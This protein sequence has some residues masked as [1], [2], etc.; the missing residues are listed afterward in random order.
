MSMLSISHVRLPDIPEE[1]LEDPTPAANAMILPLQMQSTTAIDITPKN[2]NSLEDTLEMLAARS[3]SGGSGNAGAASS[4]TSTRSIRATDSEN[5]NSTAGAENSVMAPLVREKTQTAT[6]SSVPAQA[7]Q[8]G[9]GNDQSG[10]HHDTDSTSSGGATTAAP[11]PRKSITEVSTECP[12]NYISDVSKLREMIRRKAKALDSSDQARA[13]LESTVSEYV[14]LVTSLQK[15]IGAMQMQ[16]LDDSLESSRRSM[17]ELVRARTHNL[18]SSTSDYISHVQLAGGSS[19]SSGTGISTGFPAASIPPTSGAGV[20]RTSVLSTGGAREEDP[21]HGGT[22]SSSSAPDM[23]ELQRVIAEKTADISTLRQQLANADAKSRA[24]QLQLESDFMLI[25][26]EQQQRVWRDLEAQMHGQYRVMFAEYKARK[27]S[28]AQ[29]VCDDAKEALQREA[30]DLRTRVEKEWSGREAALRDEEA[31]RFAIVE[32]QRSAERG[33]LET[34]VKAAEKRAQAA[35]SERDALLEKQSALEDD[36]TQKLVDLEKKLE[37]AMEMKR[38]LENAAAADRE[39]LSLAE[40]EASGLAATHEAKLRDAISAAEEKAKRAAEAEIGSARAALEQKFEKEADRW[41]ADFVKAKETELREIREKVEQHI[42][43]YTSEL[44]RKIAAVEN[45]EKEVAEK[46]TALTQ[47]QAELEEKRLALENEQASFRDELQAELTKQTE[48][49]IASE[50]ARLARLASDTAS[51]LDDR[52]ASMKTA[53]EDREASMKTAL[54]DREASMQT[55]LEDSKASMKTALEEKEAAMKAALEDKEAS[56]KAAFAEALEAERAKLRAEAAEAI[57]AEEASLKAEADALL[58]KEREQA[59]AAL[60]RERE[61]LRATSQLQLQ[62]LALQ[63][64]DQAANVKLKELEGREQLLAE[65]AEEK[66]RCVLETK[67]Q[68]LVDATREKKELQQQQEEAAKSREKM[69]REGFERDLQQERERGEAEA[70]R[71]LAA[72]VEPLTAQCNAM[73]EECASLRQQIEEAQKV[74]E[75]ERHAALAEAKELWDSHHSADLQLQ[76]EAHE[77]KLQDA[78][79]KA[80]EETRTTCEQERDKYLADAGQAWEKS[81][82]D[83]RELQLSQD[84]QKAEAEKIAAVETLNAER[85]VFLAKSEIVQRE[86]AD[87]ETRMAEVETAATALEDTRRATDE[88]HELRLK[89]L[90][91]REEALKVRERDVLEK[92]RELSQRAGELCLKGSELLLRSEELFAKE[93]VLEK[94]MLGLKKM[95][96]QLQDDVVLSS[97]DKKVVDRN[98][99]GGNIFSKNVASASAVDVSSTTKSASSSKLTAISS[100]SSKFTA[101]THADEGPHGSGSGSS[102]SSS[103]SSPSWDEITPVEHEQLLAREHN[104]LARKYQE[105]VTAKAT[106]EV[107]CA[108][109][110][111]DLEKRD[112]AIDHLKRKHKLELNIAVQHTRA[113]ERKRHSQTRAIGGSSGTTIGGGG[114][115]EGQHR[116]LDHQEHQTAGALPSSQRHSTASSGS[117]SSNSV[118]PTSSRAVTASSVEQEADWVRHRMPENNNVVTSHGYGAPSTM[119]TSR[120]C[121]HQLQPHTSASQQRPLQRNNFSTRSS[122]QKQHAVLMLPASRNTFS[123]A[124]DVSIDD[125]SGTVDEHE[126]DEDHDC[127]ARTSG[128]CGTSS[129][130]V[131]VSPN[132]KPFGGAPKPLWRSGAIAPKIGQNLA[133]SANRLNNFK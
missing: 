51:A 85:E 49:L 90:H 55:A 19:P 79:E 103:S 89:E 93:R 98:W 58:A 10:Q 41:K 94:E 1:G 102:G 22:S 95:N 20:T 54:E 118:P 29:R 132:K 52:E 74:S 86:R 47:E 44:S 127:S 73:Q 131:S 64:E 99:G 30:A 83:E 107:E 53:L 66:R 91:R 65:Q 2:S 133:R 113:K 120:T 3:K 96:E 8:H 23:R 106:L 6:S 82:A 61:E 25:L 125:D 43:D 130:V 69:L 7:P 70:R 12:E 48:E 63:M 16:N 42:G 88:E 28:E 111:R 18:S 21:C 76:E 119:S 31:A 117:V 5:A 32:E 36:Y 26:R 112:E 72:E 40:D 17:A 38:S 67:R 126:A 87:L 78:I 4:S 105:V 92:D 9:I 34:Q 121:P 39:R 14:E 80:I 104:Q 15:E 77:R 11:L 81:L 24:A 27:Q 115:G 122:P 124:A 128:S 100:A 60:E 75:Q 35:S 129:R 68:A 57:E 33:K 109:F 97:G 116:H 114:A 123:R 59:A 13:K 37:D 71:L 50:R 56:M 108:K 101:T 110:R 45:K 84:K 46:K 62:E